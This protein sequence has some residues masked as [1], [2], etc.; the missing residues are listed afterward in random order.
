[1]KLSS[2]EFV[3]VDGKQCV[4]IVFHADEV[5]VTVDTKEIYRADNSKKKY[6]GRPYKPCVSHC[7]IV[8]RHATQ[9]K[10]NPDHARA[11]RGLRPKLMLH[12][13]EETS[14]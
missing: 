2:A 13:G 5:R 9:R 7:L 12:A 3:F 10:Q 8:Y 1:M 14:P 6:G 4:E 11:A